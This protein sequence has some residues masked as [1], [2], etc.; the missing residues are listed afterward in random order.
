MNLSYSS[1]RGI[2]D[3]SHFWYNKIMKANQP[4]RPAFIAG[5]TTHLL[6]QQDTK[7]YID[8]DFNNSEYFFSKPWGEAIMRGYIDLVNWKSKCFSEIKTGRKKKGMGWFKKSN[9]WRLYSKMLGLKKVLFVFAEIDYNNEVP[10]VVSIKNISKY[11]Y[12]IQN[13]DYE[14]LDEWVQYAID[15]IKNG[16]YLKDKTCDG[17]FYGENCLLRI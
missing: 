6:L 17:C 12:E 14:P 16:D 5:K 7:K 15:H 2:H 9:Q 13:K 1:I 8:W 3:S 11:Y 10:E 4:D